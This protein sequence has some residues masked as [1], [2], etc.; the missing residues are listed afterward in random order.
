MKRIC[1]EINTQKKKPSDLENLHFRSRLSQNLALNNLL[2]ICLWRCLFQWNV[3]IRNFACVEG[4]CI[5]L[6]Q[7]IQFCC[8][9][10]LIYKNFSPKKREEEKWKE[11]ALK[12]IH[13]KKSRQ[14][15]KI[16]TFDRGYLRI[17]LWKSVEILLTSHN[18]NNPEK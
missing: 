17:R 5:Y 1:I 12:L 13:K 2:S 16:C 7:S 4:T 3:G 11:Y 9:I 10:S 18:T 6:K 15:W 8:L 14:I